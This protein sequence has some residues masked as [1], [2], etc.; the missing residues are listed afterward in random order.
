MREKETCALFVTLS[1]AYDISQRMK[2]GRFSSI[3]FQSAVVNVFNLNFSRK[4]EETQL[5]AL[6][7]FFLSFYST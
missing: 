4:T 2:D 1:I 7:L 6:I 3:S 5:T